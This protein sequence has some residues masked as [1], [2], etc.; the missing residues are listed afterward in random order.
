MFKTFPSI[1][2]TVLVGIGGGIPRTEV[3]EDT[4]ENLHLGDVV[5]GWP[6]DSKPVCIYYERGRLKTDGHELLGVTQ[7][8]DW[9]LTNA[10]TKLK[11]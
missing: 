4:L 1:Q 5:V 6:G 9:R 11:R 10:I 7:N 3:S 2:M 8:P